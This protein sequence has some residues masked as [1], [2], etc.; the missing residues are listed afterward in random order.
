MSRVDLSGVTKLY[1]ETRAVESVTLTVNEGEFFGLLGPSGSGKSTLLRLVAGFIQPT[2]GTIHI[3][4]ER[5]EHI[6]PSRRQIGMVFQSYAL[7]PHLDVFRNVAFGLEVRRVPRADIARRV[8][9]VLA[10]V[11]LVGLEHRRPSQLSGGQQQ[12]VALARAL[13][14]RPKVLLLDEPLGAL[15]RRLR[16]EMQVEL[17]QIQRRVGITTIFVTHDQEEALTLSDRVALMRA[18]R[19][20]QA[21]TPQEVYDHPV[22]TFAAVF[23]GDSNFLFGTR[24]ASTLVRLDLGP[25]VAI[26]AGRHGAGERV[27]LTIRPERLALSPP[28]TT[29]DGVFPGTVT[30]AI[31]LG[32]VLVYL[33]TLQGGTTVRVALRHE[34]QRI[35]A[36]GEPVAVRFALDAFQPVSE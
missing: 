20:V 12:R 18:G 25:T 34:G 6:P 9:D 14:I 10:L 1:G 13:V 2:Q 31:F 3:G 24:V 17:R 23:L 11:Q 33:V 4:G 21:G 8:A 35:H 29:G 16:A 27:T 22:S 36:E 30:R 28:G 32:P 26:P 5:V 7:F 15:D 19:I